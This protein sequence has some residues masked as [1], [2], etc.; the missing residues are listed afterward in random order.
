MSWM[1]NIIYLLGLI[2]GSPFLLYKS[3]RTGKYRHG[4]AGRLGC[5][6]SI[7]IEKLRVPAGQAA[8]RRILLHCVSV[9]ELLSMGRLIEELLAADVGLQIVVSTTTDTG[10]ARALAIYGQSPDARV[11]PVRFPLD[12]SCAV[13]RFLETVQPQFIV[14]V[15]LETWPNF[16]FAAHRRGISVRIINGRLTE[17]S[18][19]RYR[20][21]RPLVAAMFARVAKFG[22]Q[23]Q[24][25]AERF[26][27]LGAPADRVEIIPTVK[28]DAADFSDQIPGSREMAIAIGVQ[29]HHQVL[30]CGSTGPGEEYPLLDMYQAMSKDYPDLR[31]AIAPRKPEVVAAVHAAIEARGFKVIRRSERPDGTVGPALAATDIV[32]LDTMGELKKLYG[33]AFGIFSGRSLVR[34]GGSD[35]IEAAALARP[36]C[37]GPHTFNFAEA[38]EALLAAQAAVR[39]HDAASLAS[40]VRQWL[41]DA[42]GAREMGL[43][44]RT[45]L[46]RMRGSTHRYASDILAA[47]NGL[48]ARD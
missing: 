48:S 20:L 47:V 14:L 6:D 43:R 8:P 10:M 1:L 27:A 22:V 4:W 21:V 13:N 38:V 44:G 46:L 34:L 29:D 26:T 3:C 30:A 18:F 33:L 9:G 16:I 41:Q 12:I 19:R 31:L 40:A 2:L 23:T 15:E 28:Y 45:C 5:L 35:M 25:I 36:V 39:V 11:V 7:A 37:F 17:K 32:L 42:A 24:A